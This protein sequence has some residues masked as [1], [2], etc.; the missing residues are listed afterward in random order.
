VETV[1]EKPNYFIIDPEKEKLRKSF[2]NSENVLY[3]II[4]ATKYRETAFIRIPTEELPNTITIRDLKINAVRYWLWNCERFQFYDFPFNAY[5]SVGKFPNMPV[6]SWN[7]KMRREEMDRWNRNFLAEMTEYDFLM[8]IDNPDLRIAYA[9][10][11]KTMQILREAQV[12]YSCVFSGNKGWHIRISYEDFSPEMKALPKP[13][14]VTMLKKFAEKFTAV[15]GLYSI[16][17]SI[18]DTRRIGKIPYSVV[19]P[20]YYIALPLSDAEMDNFTLE[21]CTMEHWLKPE[22]MRKLY[23]RG[24]LKREGR[25]GAFGE[26]VQKYGVL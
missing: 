20:K 9:T 6:F 15:N 22:N 11:Y 3:N 1:I 17:L 24:L 13:G 4:E 26:L 8:D 5:A 18:F 12:A 16:D 21:Y 23:Q 25:P 2:Y 7:P 19:Y 14:L 10:A